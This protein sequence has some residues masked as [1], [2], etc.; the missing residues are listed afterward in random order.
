MTLLVNH[1]LIFQIF[2]LSS[3]L[4]NIIKD[5]DSGRPRGFA[6]VVFEDS[7]AAYEAVNGANG[8]VR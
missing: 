8:C 3:L 7:S 5:R 6:F 2:V 4:V 1:Y